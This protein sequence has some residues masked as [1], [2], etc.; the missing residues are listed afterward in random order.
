M[1][2]C[3]IMCADMAAAGLP[4]NGPVVF[5][6]SGNIV[7]VLGNG[8]RLPEAVH[9][10]A[11]NGVLTWTGTD[12]A[13]GDKQAGVPLEQTAAWSN[14]GWGQY[15]VIC[16]PSPGG[17]QPIADFH[18]H[19]PAQSTAQLATLIV[20]QQPSG[21]W[22]T[23]G[24]STYDLAVESGTFTGTL[25]QYLASLRGPAGPKGDYGFTG[26][27]NAND[28]PD[29]VR[30][31]AMHSR[32][33]PM[34]V[35]VVDSRPTLD[36]VIPLGGD[37][38]VRY[39]LRRDQNDDYWLLDSGSV[40]TIQHT[41]TLTSRVNYSAT[42]GGYVTSSPP[43][44]FTT[45]VGATASAQFTGT[46]VDWYSYCDQRGGIW[47][48]VIDAGTANEVTKTIS[49]W[50]ASAAAIAQTIATGLTDGP[51]TLTATFAGADPANAANPGPARGWIYWPTTSAHTETM[52]RVYR[53]LPSFVEG[54]ELL[55]ST[56][57]KEFAL[58]GRPAGSG[59][60]SQ[61][62]PEHNFVGT[63]FAVDSARVLADGVPVPLTVGT[64]L[65]G[66]GTLQLVQKVR[67]VHPSD[68][69]NPLCEITTVHTIRDGVAA[70]AG[71]VKW[72]RDTEVVTG[73]GPMLPYRASW[74][75]WVQTSQGV[76]H[77]VQ[78]PTGG[79][80]YE[81]LPEKFDLRSAV[82]LNATS[83]DPA[84]RYAALAWTVDNVALSL[85]LGAEGANPD[86]A[87]I[88]HRNATF[89]KVYLQV[90]KNVVMPA[91]T[92]YTFSSRQLV[93]W[94]EAVDSLILT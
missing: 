92:E 36:A 63:A 73:Y 80:V 24:K 6:P 32:R 86:G 49:T 14:G 35:S 50:R 76:R 31:L 8:L 91:G 19:V 7:G 34:T 56:S 67:G 33:G 55:A 20:A 1:P 71:R 38:A 45:T 26:T 47:T 60:G 44:C 15:R 53:A 16:P 83:T 82:V 93:T 78:R 5:L 11:I 22:V 39:R 70:I 4:A 28:Q 23:Q 65:E 51:H 21:G 89:G 85:R 25:S 41:D 66:V 72:L 58:N 90:F 77:P 42:T 43:H 68:P 74:A 64:R 46:R 17:G 48:I 18:I 30:D 59:D 57:N 37:R 13:P 79:G 69:S 61:W 94:L 52:L 29:Y 10:Q 62:V 84:L 54:Q 2:T 81:T 87:S 9:A 3:R 12:R 40:G 75:D 27:I 88:E